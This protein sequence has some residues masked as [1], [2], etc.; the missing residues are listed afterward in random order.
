VGD[1][2]QVGWPMSDRLTSHHAMATVYDFMVLN[3]D[4]IRTW[5]WMCKYGTLWL[6]QSASSDAL[7]HAGCKT[8]ELDS[9]S[10]S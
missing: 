6:E 4:K 7:S 9:F 3:E 5:P 8:Y 10:S 1:D 2:A